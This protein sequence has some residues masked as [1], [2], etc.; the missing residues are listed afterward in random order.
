M[1]IFGK[2]PPSFHDQLEGLLTE[3]LKAQP[4]NQAARLKLLELYYETHR[5][6][7]FLRAAQELAD[8]TPNKAA[9]PEWQKILVD[10]PPSA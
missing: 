1:P 6:A 2:E 9:S 4:R 3:Q 10:L 5:A 7:Q 8:L